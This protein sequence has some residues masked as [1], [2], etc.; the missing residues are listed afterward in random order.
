MKRHSATA[1]T[2]KAAALISLRLPIEIKKCPENNQ[3]VVFCKPLWL[4]TQGATLKEARESIHEVIAMY[5][6]HC[7]GQGTLEESLKQK[8]WKRGRAKNPP[9]RVVR[10]ETATVKIPYPIPLPQG[11]PAWARNLDG[12]ANVSAV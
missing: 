10:Q 2:G 12:G 3:Y 6:E 8:G 7:L 4:S 9:A 5:F 1:K 11:A